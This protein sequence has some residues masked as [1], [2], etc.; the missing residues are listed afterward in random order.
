MTA[1]PTRLPAILG[2]IRGRGALVALL[3][4]FL[5]ATLR[6][7]VF[8]TPE[9]LLN[10]LRQNSM[11]GLLA[12]GMTFVVITGGIDLSAG[13]FVAIA[14]VVAALLSSYGAALAAPG[15]IACTCLLGAMNGLL[16]ARARVPPF[17][18]TLCVMIAS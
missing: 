2:A 6:Y 3:L 13:A 10:V 8:M 16:V 9:N 4:V 5:F 7:E 14:G 11:L 18:A 12:L 17:I 1:P 15:A